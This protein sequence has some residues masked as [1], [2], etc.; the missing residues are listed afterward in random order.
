MAECQGKHRRLDL[1][2]LMLSKMKMIPETAPV[3]TIQDTVYTFGF[4]IGVDKLETPKVI[5]YVDWK[6]VEA[7]LWF[8]IFQLRGIYSCKQRIPPIFELR[9]TKS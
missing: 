6:G 5:P 2:A 8:T 1:K 9:D 4:L 7:E 3:T